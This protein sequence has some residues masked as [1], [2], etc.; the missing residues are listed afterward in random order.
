MKFQF[1]HL[2]SKRRHH[3][4]NDPRVTKDGET[5]LQKER[6][7]NKRNNT[8]EEINT[9]IHQGRN[10]SMEGLIV[11]KQLRLNSWKGWLF[12]TNRLLEVFLGNRHSVGEDSEEEE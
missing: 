1:D 12:K 9:Y 3:L 2:L 4:P 6:L 11:F 5:I 8:K 7:I 10:P